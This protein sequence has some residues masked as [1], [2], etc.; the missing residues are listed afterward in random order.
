MRVIG[1]N[2]TKISIEKLKELT[3]RPKV[4]NE[5]DVPEIIEAKPGILK[6]KED[7][8]EAKFE[9]KVA[10]EPKLANI[11]LEGRILLSLEP[12]IAKE[13]L[14]QWKKKKM[15][16]E[17]RNLLFNIILRKSSLKALQ[18]EDELNLPIH[19]PLPSLKKPDKEK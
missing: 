17:F 4:T 12:K 8:L 5:I 11:N 14:K 16:E 13:V 10:Y 9:Y 15:P 2:F 3:E 1:F 6:T 18:L 19:M 7:I